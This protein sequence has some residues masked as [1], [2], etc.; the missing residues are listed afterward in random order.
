MLIKM[1]NYI[2]YKKALKEKKQNIFDLKRVEFNTKYAKECFYCGK[3]IMGHRYFGRIWI[4]EQ[5]EDGNNTIH[6]CDEYI[7][8]TP[9]KHAEANRKKSLRRSG[10]IEL[11]IEMT[12]KKQYSED[13]L[14]GL[15]S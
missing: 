8:A 6:N 1:S 10:V 5:D 11:R 13:R 3:I 7:N 9:E 12:I 4:I 15:F 2:V 14:R